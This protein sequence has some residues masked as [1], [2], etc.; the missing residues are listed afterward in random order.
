VAGAVALGHRRVAEEL[1]NSRA[2]G[3]PL[4]A[5]AGAA[6]AQLEARR[7]FRWLLVAG[8]SACSSASRAS[9]GWR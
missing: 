8:E 5:A 7:A 6:V 3:G 4:R 1:G 2:D 9:G